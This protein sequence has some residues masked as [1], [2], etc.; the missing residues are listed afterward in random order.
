MKNIKFRYRFFY[1]WFQLLDFALGRP[2]GKKLTK[3][4]RKFF[5]DLLHISLKKSGVGKSIEVSRVKDLSIAQIKKQFIDKGIPVVIEGAANEWVCTKNWSLEYFKELH[6]DDDVTLVG[7]NQDEELFQIKKLKTVISNLQKGLQDYLR[8]YPLLSLHPEH[9]NDFD[10][11]WLRKARTNFS[12]WE[13]F[14]VFIGGKGSNTTNHNAIASNFFIQAY[15]EK[16]WILY[17]PSYTSVIDPNPGENMHRSGPAKLEE[18]AFD[19][20]NPNYKQPYH[21]YQYLDHINVLLKPGDVFYNPP[22]YWHTVRNNSDSIGIGYRWVSRK[23]AL[24]AAPFYTLL[25]IVKIP[26]SK[27]LRENLK[28]DYYLIFLMEKDL[29]DDYLKKSN[30]A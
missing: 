15:G 16:E 23:Q 26:F 11:K 30:K 3:R 9:I 2:L 17:P 6:G 25:D 14:Q 18:G 1:G 22:H 29:M 28:K 21:L 27:R 13:T 4:S 24:V 12:F 7:T 5:Y 19:P 10:Y 8:F 20:F